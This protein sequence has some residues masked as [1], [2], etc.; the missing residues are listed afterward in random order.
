MRLRGIFGVVLVLASGA[1]AF[2]WF[3]PSVE[4]R[5]K[6]GKLFSSLSFAAGSEKAARHL[7]VSA[8]GDLVADELVVELAEGVRSF[9]DG[10][11]DKESLLA[12][13]RYLADSARSSR[14]GPAE[15]RRVEV[16]GGRGE[17]SVAFPIRVDANLGADVDGACEAVLHWERG[18]RGWRLGKVCI[19]AH[20]LAAREE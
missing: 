5:R 3:S 18:E 1:F 9:P 7:G 8:A 4:L 13:F 12:G 2:H 10:T 17:V 19:E 11:I 20:R 15:F 16:R 14:F 6:T